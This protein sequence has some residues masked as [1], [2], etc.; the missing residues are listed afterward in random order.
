MLPIKRLLN[1][2]FLW[3]P[4]EKKGSRFRIE[5]YNSEIWGLIGDLSEVSHLFI[6][7]AIICWSLSIYHLISFVRWK[8]I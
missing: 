1:Q 8:L 5:N 6:R 4:C 7:S 3:L 2:Y